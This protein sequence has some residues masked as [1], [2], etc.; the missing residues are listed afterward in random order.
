MR[1]ETEYNPIRRIRA[2]AVPGAWC[3]V[4]EPESR[5]DDPRGVG[6]AHVDGPEAL[7]FS[8]RHS[9]VRGALLGADHHWVVGPTRVGRLHGAFPPPWAQSANEQAARSTEWFVH[10]GVRVRLRD[11]PALVRGCLIPCE[12]WG[13]GL[14]LRALEAGTGTAYGVQRG[15]LPTRAWSVLLPPRPQ[16]SP[17]HQPL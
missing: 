1:D 3:P 6:K 12:R 8:G 11:G 4:G 14:S 2:T 10:E 7:L 9:R 13:I 16:A 15:P 17:G 5:A